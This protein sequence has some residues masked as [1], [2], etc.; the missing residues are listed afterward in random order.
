[1]LGSF[2]A[3][4][5]L[6]NTKFSTNLS[7]KIS[8]H[9]HFSQ[10]KKLENKRL[11]KVDSLQFNVLFYQLSDLADPTQIVHL[12]ELAKKLKLIIVADTEQFANFA[13]EVGAV[14]FLTTD[15]SQQRLEKCFD[16][17]IHLCPLASAAEQQYQ[18]QKQH[19]KSHSSHI[20]VKDVGKVRLIDPNDIVWV[21]GAGNYVE[22]HFKED[23][24]PIL[25][26]ETMKNIE[27]Q[28]TPEGFIRIHRSTLV[29]RD[30]I[31]E[32]MPTDSGDYKIKLK[33]DTCL[34]L[35][36]RYKNCLESIISPF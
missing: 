16:K 23:T 3:L 32:L 22:L 17:L 28:L 31:T 5:W 10:L 1:M 12:A 21:N 19:Q 6:K 11:D 34:N 9:R 25:H 30:A 18:E 2:N 26:R 4:T 35:S 8:T 14:D 24:K 29:R 27:Q 20:V 7:G 36:R 33:N 13:F 15:V